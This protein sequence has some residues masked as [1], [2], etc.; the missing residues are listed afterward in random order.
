[1]AIQLR[2]ILVKA[3]RQLESERAHLD[4]QIAAVQA[5]LGTSDSGNRS[6]VKTRSRKPRT[7]SVAARRKVS[8][9]MRNYWA[10]RKKAAARAKVREL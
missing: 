9:S 6:T 3:L 5:V 1:M 2:G 7:M 8:Q 4:R 10:D